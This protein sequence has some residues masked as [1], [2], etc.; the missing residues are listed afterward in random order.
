MS[1]LAARLLRPELSDLVPYESA[2]RLGGKGEVWLNANENP[3]RH[4][5]QLDCGRFNRYP[6][7]QPPE[8]IARYAAYAGVTQHELLA[9]RGADEGN[10]LPR[11]C[12]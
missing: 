3:Y 6:E 1:D 10:G 9:S 12:F 11:Q 8:L 4:D 7:F 5:Y 2:R